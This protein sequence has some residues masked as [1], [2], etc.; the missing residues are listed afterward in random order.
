MIT[1]KNYE[2]LYCVSE[3][4]NIT[5]QLYNSMKKILKGIAGAGIPLDISK[6]GICLIQR[7]L[8]C[9]TNLFSFSESLQPII[10]WFSSW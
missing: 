8:I 10:F 1:F 9:S 4:Y 5:H 6:S 3:T 2:S 7:M